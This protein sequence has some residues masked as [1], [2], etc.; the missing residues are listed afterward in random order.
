VG[1]HL[2]DLARDLVRRG[3]R[4]VVYTSA[5]GYDDPSRRFPKRETRGGVEIVRIGRGSLGKGRMGS[6]ILGGIWF[7]AAATLR[8]LLR[9]RYDALL[10]STSPPMASAAAVVVSTIRRPRLFFWVMDVNPDQA[11]A[12]GTVSQSSWLARAL[13]ASHRAAAR[14]SRRVVLL[15]RFMAER[16]APRW[17]ME[18]V[19][20]PPWPH[21]EGLVSIP[22][23]ANPFRA[24]HGLEGKLVILYSGNLSPVHPVTTALEAA[25]RLR[26]DERVV[27][28]FIGGGQGREAVEAAAAEL[29]NV[30]L[31]P[32]QPFEQ[33]S[34]SLS[35]GD[36]HLVSMGEDM[37]GIVHPCKVYGAMAVARP[38][39]YLGPQE[40][41]V[42]DMLREADVG[43]RVDHGDVAGFVALV[44]EIVTSPRS[45]L[46]AKGARGRELI[47]TRYSQERL[48]GALAEEIVAGLGG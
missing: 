39:L 25:R 17:P 12:T 18:A 16:L 41:H 27:F 19:V 35:A 42:G 33:L 1:Q 5:R 14:R 43:W 10:F 40:S 26:D 7:L 20:L 3:L 34:W 31:L 48:R 28:L 45:A 44:E 30:R 21:E 11:I 4:V 36:V 2:H 37:V 15:D 13:E 6:R 9:R 8:C 24:E 46:E 22:P 47:D 29:P 38:I 32:Y 23:E